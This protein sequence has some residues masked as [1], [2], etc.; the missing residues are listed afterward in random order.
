MYLPAHFVGPSKISEPE[1]M[2]CSTSQAST[3]RSS[4]ISSIWRSTPFFSSIT[5]PSFSIASV[6]LTGLRCQ[7]SA[8]RTVSLVSQNMAELPSS[9]S[10]TPTSA[11]LG[12]AALNASVGIT[13]VTMHQLASDRSISVAAGSQYTL[14]GRVTGLMRISWSNASSLT[15]CV[16]MRKWPMPQLV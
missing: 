15:Y 3:S 8:T 7:Y 2:Y 12:Y 1:T 4:L 14:R 6:F 5:L 10:S 16:R 11:A 9:R 13:S